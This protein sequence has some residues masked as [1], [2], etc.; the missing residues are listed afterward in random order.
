MSVCVKTTPAVT[1]GL[2][3]DELGQAGFHTPMTFGH[4]NM[5]RMI[6]Y[7]QMF[8]WAI[9]PQEY[10][11]NER[12]EGISILVRQILLFLFWHI[13]YYHKQYVKKKFHSLQCIDLK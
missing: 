10:E 11:I 5:M 6:R 7:T 1:F 2:G 4:S 12:L 9:P 8:L 13:S 3:S